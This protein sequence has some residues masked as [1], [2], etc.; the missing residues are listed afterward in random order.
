MNDPKSWENQ[1]ENWVPRR[2]SERV[3]ARLFGRSRAACET[4]PSPSMVAWLVPA[5]LCG[6][7]LLMMAG[8]GRRPIGI[9]RPT[10]T[11]ALLA[12][13]LWNGLAVSNRS[14]EAA[15]VP[16]VILMTARSGVEWNVWR[17]ATFEW[18][19]PRQSPSSM[20]SFPYLKTNILRRKP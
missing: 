3:R 6:L 7:L 1:F 20:P 18:T 5:A 10:D 9:L 16:P 19:N 8:G 2:P 13:I 11:N 15:I 14:S 12:T 4:A 17:E